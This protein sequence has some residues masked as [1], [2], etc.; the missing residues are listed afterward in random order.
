MVSARE[1]TAGLR[2]I[3]GRAVGQRTKETPTG[4]HIPVFKQGVRL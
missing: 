1:E 2:D 4:G 3:P